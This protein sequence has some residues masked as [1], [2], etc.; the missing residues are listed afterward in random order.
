MRRLPLLCAAAGL[1]LAALAA[2]SPAQ[3]GYHLIKWDVT[4]FCQVWDENIPIQPFPTTYKKVS[5]SVP[6][7]IDILSVKD[8]MVRAGPCAF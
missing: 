5:A 3:A 1:S 6:S 4:G 2:T 7:L 8:S